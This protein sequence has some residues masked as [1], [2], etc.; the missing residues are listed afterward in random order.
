MNFSLKIFFA[1]LFIFCFTIKTLFGQELKIMVKDNDRQPLIGA[2]IQ[3]INISDST[4][5]ARV[6]GQNGI[7]V[8]DAVKNGLY[9]VKI[10]YVGFQAIEKII[11]LKT[12]RNTLDFQL[13]E[14]EI[15]LKEVS[16]TARK[17]LIT[18]EDDK[19]I[20]DPEP[21][22]NSSTNTLE[23]L[24]STPGLYVDQ[25]G[26]IFLNGASPA[27]IY[28]NGREQKMSTEDIATLLRSLPPGSVQRIEIMRTPST[29][30]DASSTG[31]I[32]NVILKK[33]VKI[34]RFMSMNIGMNQGVYGNRFA[35]FSLNNSSDKSTTYLNLNYNLN[36][37][38]EDLNSNRYLNKDTVL[39]QSNKLRRTSNQMYVGYGFTYDFTD[40]L[41]F[42]YDGRINANLP[43]TSSRST[44]LIETLENIQLSESDNSNSGS[45]IFM[46]VQ[47]DFGL[48]FKIDTLGSNWD[49]KLSF[50]INK[51]SS[52][53]DYSSNYSF[54]INFSFSGDGSNNQN[55]YFIEFQ[56]DLTYQLPLKFK[57]ETGIKSSYQ[58]YNS[59]TDYFISI[60]GNRTSDPSRTNAFNYQELINAAYA[61][62]SKTF[63][64]KLLL[65][66]GVRVE[67]T[68]MNGVQ[69]IPTDTSFVLNRV[70]WFPYVYLSRPIFKIADFELRAYLIY[71]KTI[72]RPDYQSLNPYRK[73]IDELEYETGNP[74]LKPQFTDNIE[75]NVSFDDTPLFAIGQN[76]TNDIFSSVVYRDPSNENISVR[77]FDN[78]GKSKETYFRGMAGIPPGKKY[79]FGAGAQYNLNEYDGV[80]QN[81][82]LKYTRGS[83]R[84]F[85]FHSLQLFKNT[86]LTM[87]G[88]MM[89]NGNYNFY[90][91][92]TF[93][94]LN[95]GLNQT[96]LN[97]KLTITLNARDVLRT[98]VT[99]FEL[100]QGDIRSS[101]SRYTDNQRF[102]INIRYN[103]GIRKKEDKKGSMGFEPEE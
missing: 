5:I 15:S 62:A 34:G 81:M 103:F 46:N 54:P 36:D 82:P 7:A 16:I 53:Q 40:K 1:S 90:E 78:I 92:N 3:I 38:V 37:V 26:N 60:N 88:F 85:T 23:V 22:A 93:G 33:G 47:Q 12:Q 2:T 50:S 97:K 21:I 61:Q 102:G 30:Y 10:S 8:F 43:K 41:N 28:I 29:K 96:F 86:K 19:M 27:T 59:N 17:P 91:L 24:E 55:R 56:S 11:T 95:F 89:T 70:D 87:F 51:N 77:T 14:K 31:G 101:G 25:D 42:S 76:Y 52:D 74:F 64:W 98:M 100:N 39:Y 45:S 66:T 49:T 83:W 68:Y 71:R 75:M 73:Y 80:Y 69:T 18:Q 63:A 13:K 6:T 72:N 48:I 65:K 84:F 58:N 67:Q 20:I 35:G 32:V 57:V 9:E 44:N 94:S 4:S 99:Q 79:F